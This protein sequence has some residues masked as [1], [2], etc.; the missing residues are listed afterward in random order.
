MP[1]GGFKIPP[2]A[3]FPQYNAGP[4]DRRAFSV[5]LKSSGFPFGSNTI[6]VIAW[7]ARLQELPHI[8]YFPLSICIIRH[9]RFRVGKELI[10]AGCLS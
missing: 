9:N 5:N 7:C 2:A 4:T 3:L 10:Q 8:A 1:K 6:Q